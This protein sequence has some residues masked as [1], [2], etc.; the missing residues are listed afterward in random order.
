VLVFWRGLT[1]LKIKN[2]DYDLDDGGAA[3]PYLA[4]R[5]HTQSTGF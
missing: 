4:Q 1:W 3:P 5:Q 2:P